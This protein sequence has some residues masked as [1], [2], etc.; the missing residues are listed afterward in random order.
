MDCFFASEGL[1]ATLA[2]LAI[3]A[4]LAGREALRRGYFTSSNVIYAAVQSD[5]KPCSKYGNS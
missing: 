2:I 1:L 5:I 3:L 4:T